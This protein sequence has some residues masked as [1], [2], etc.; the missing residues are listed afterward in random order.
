MGILD[1]FREWQKLGNRKFLPRRR[2]AGTPPTASTAVE[3]LEYRRMLTATLSGTTLQVSGS[4]GGDAIVVTQDSTGATVT[5]NGVTTFS[6]SV[7]TINAVQIVGGTGDDSITIGG[8]SVG[9]TLTV[10]GGSGTNTLISPNQANEWDITGANSG[11]LNGNSFTNIQ[12]LV[13]GGYNDDFVFQGGYVQGSIDGGG[14]LNALDYSNL[15]VGAVVNLANSTATDIGTGFV[16]VSITDFHGSFDTTD[17]LISAN[18][19]NTW[20]IDGGDSGDING[21]FFFTG[22][23]NLVGGSGNDTFVFGAAGFVEGSISGGLGSNTLD[24]S[25]RTTGIVANLQANEAT[26]I[27]STFDQIGTIIGSNLGDDL[28][29][30]N[31]YTNLWNITSANAGTVTS[32]FTSM[33]FQGFADL[34]GG[35]MNDTFQFAD[36]AFVSG[37]VDGGAGTNTLDYSLRTDSIS[38]N[39]QTTIATGI[40]GGFSGIQS[41]V[42]NDLANGVIIGANVVNTWNITS[43]DAGN[44]NGLLYS[45]F[46]NLTG[47]TSN[48]S[49]VMGATGVVAGTLSGGT[50]SNTLDYSNRTASIVANLQTN[51]ATAIGNGF[52]GITN[53]VGS[54]LGGDSL[55]GN[56][57]TST[58]TIN[59]TNAGSVTYGATTISFSAIENLYGG[60]GNDT[61]A[62]VT[63]GSVA[64]IISGGAGTNTLDFSADANPITVNLQT[65]TVSGI[66]GTF[67]G[68]QNI[69]GSSIG[70]DTL[71]GANTNNIWTITG[72]NSGNINNTFSFTGF[73][74]LTGGTL[75]DTFRLLTPGFV[76]GVI[77]GGLGSNTVDYS[78]RTNGAV[79][80]L[81]T[82]AATSIGG[83]FTAIQSFIGSS[84]ADDLLIGA[85]TANTWNITG[86]NS[87]NVNGTTFFTGIKNLTGGSLND[88]FVFSPT[89]FVSGSIVGGTG[90]NTLDYSH[91][92]AGIVTNLQTNTSTAIGKTFSSISLIIGSNLGSDLLIGNN[93]VNLWDITG[94]NSGVVTSP[95]TTTNFQGIA[96]LQGGSLNDT[97]RF[98]SAGSVSGNVNGQGGTNTLDYST[99]STAI[100][101][102]LF[103][104][105]STSIGG[106]FASIGNLIGSGSTNDTL[107]AD[108]TF[109]TWTI[110]GANSG[111]IN[112]KFNFSSIENLTGGTNVDVFSFAGGGSVSGN[113]N[114]A[115]PETIATGDWL[116]YGA[117]SVN[118]TVNLA[119]GTANNIGHVGNVQN[120]H[121]GS[122]VNSLTGSSQGNILV[123]GAGS[124]TIMGG[125]GRSLLIGGLGSDTVKGGAAQD[126]VI[127]GYT[128]Y[129][130]NFVALNSI[131]AEWASTDS[132]AVRVS[133]L[134]TG[135][136]LNGSNKLIADVTVH[137]DAAPDLIYGGAGPNWLWGQPSELQDKTAQDIVDTPIDDAPILS[138]AGTVAYTVNQSPI[139]VNPT[140]V[141]TDL[142]SATLAFAT[143]RLTTN[144]VTGQDNLNFH[145]STNTGNITGNFNST[146]GILT[147]T[148][149]GATA[150]VAQFQAALRLV[151]YSNSSG[152]P[153]TL[154]R[155]VVVQVND[156]MLSSNTLM[157]TI[158]FNQAPVLASSI[159]SIQYST[160]QAATIVNSAIMASDANNLRLASAT[161]RISTNYNSNQ[162]VLIFTPNAQTGDIVGTFNSATGVMTLTAAG[163]IQDTVAQYQAALRAVA[164]QN[165]VSSPFMPQLNPRVVS[166]QVSDGSALSNVVTTTIN[167]PQVLT[168]SGTS[169]LT[170]S[171]GQMAAPINTGVTIAASST[172]GNTLNS[173]TVQISSNYVVGQDVLGFVGNASTG[174]IVAV[175]NVASG[176][177]TL[178]SSGNSLAT[179]A[180]YQA[181]LRLVTYHNTSS[182]PTKTTRVV[183]YQATGES[184][185]TSN[186]LTST[187]TFN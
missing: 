118:I 172:I 116:D 41:I 87:G 186:D 155:S 163:S 73:Q 6:N 174:N 183:T 20:H 54:T 12:S 161:V 164:Y 1:L 53:I 140:I 125:S 113:V 14:G 175:F 3:V 78:Q 165:T 68:F 38:V 66:G 8:L 105:T 25:N 62:F 59:G 74:N 187:I 158:T 184:G 46:Q 52:N 30:A 182:S 101:T 36:G 71:V 168:L 57:G 5:E 102:N 181:A 124:D 16:N 28:L 7:N 34:M 106:T 11:T 136:G 104:N 139:S 173:A 95:Y 128:D 81:Q 159:T 123:G 142:D 90:S 61:F 110:T 185:I 65:N 137:N 48:D 115:S 176:T 23:E 147:L 119:T 51:S 88:S 96:N 79:I 18:T 103:S 31:N 108:N 171:T 17:T 77:N 117:L 99:R 145:G 154:N 169:N 157:N 22:V 76:S 170:Y 58:W 64:G 80:N 160:G 132:L 177:L 156:G 32:A 40:N 82:G 138:G 109:N 24:Y 55:I 44:V 19:D 2:T 134:R 149:N 143:I 178:T 146:T 37:T 135:G 60:T 131:L 26:A 21:Q 63:G 111:N 129:D 70:S 97:F 10:D 84:G 72:A 91:R 162:D 133:D 15:I 50:G 144:Y 166:F 107:I 180:Q 148:S 112:N 167:F 49:F 69:I 27:G 89:G 151:T 150:T 42:G 141:V 152:V 114:G 153:S 127:G 67:S 33:S 93:Y 9:T 13:G 35:T 43:R 86:G 126:I 47:G 56:N 100:T 98:E 75:N 130:T 39:L 45:G 94:T 120:V 4:N 121:G 122:S 92:T 29:I 83:G 179:V 85:N